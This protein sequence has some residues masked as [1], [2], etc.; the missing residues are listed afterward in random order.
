MTQISL[1]R[2]ITVI[3]VAVLL[4]GGAVF[5]AATVARNSAVDAAR[6]QSASELM[7]TAMLN[8]ETGARG[9][10]Q[11]F[12]PVFLQPYRAGTAAFAQAL[13]ESRR[14]AGGDSALQ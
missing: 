8:Q 5:A 14:Y 13:S 1:R 10:F 12:D 9:F 4:I 6:Q 2:M 3:L 7:L 11:T